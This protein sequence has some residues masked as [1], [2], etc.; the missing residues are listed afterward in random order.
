[1]PNFSRAKSGGGGRYYNPFYNQVDSGVI[2]EL[3]K[4]AK[5]V[6]ATVRSGVD[7]AVLEWSYRKTAY[8]HVKAGGKNGIAMGFDGPRAMTDKSGN[9]T[10]YDST[11]NV[12]A[13]PLLQSIDITNDGTVGSLLRGKFNFTYWPKQNRNSFNMQKVSNLFFVPGKEAQLS[14]GWS[15]GGSRNNQAFTGIIN[16]FNWSYN[17]DLSMNAEVSIVSAAS[18][19]IGISGD[20]T[21]A[22]TDPNSKSTDGAGVAIAGINIASMI[23]SDLARIT[24]SKVMSEAG[25]TDY[26]GTSNPLNK[27]KIL[28]YVCI[29]WP[30][31]DENSKGANVQTFWYTSVTRFVE[32][33]NKLIDDFEKG[34]A[35]GLGSIFQLQV[36]GN[37]TQHLPTIKSS[38]P[39]DVVFPSVQM[40]SYGGV[41]PGSWS[42]NSFGFNPARFY[43]PATQKF[44]VPITGKSDSELINIGGILISVNYIKDTY[45]NFIQENAAN[46]SY[47]NITKFVEDVLK[48][49]NVASGDMYQLSAV[50]CDNP[51]TMRGKSEYNNL[52]IAILSIEDTNISPV[53][54]DSVTAFK[55]EGNIF[56][57]LIKNINISSKPPAPL[58]AA[59]FTK[60]RG[61]KNAN[62]D[63]PVSANKKPD[64]PKKTQDEMDAHLA[65]FASG[66]FN[67]KWSET[68]RGLQSRLK[69]VSV[70][71]KN[72]HWLT[73]AIYPV[74]LSI[75][76]DGVSGFSFG[77]IVTTNLLP[78]EYV[79]AKMVFAV[80]KIDHKI[81]PHIW[82]TTLHTVCRLDA[83]S[84][85]GTASS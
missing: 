59:A 25:Q 81:T 74:E 60:A 26:I 41:Q 83:N 51:D 29:G 82:E 78:S 16:N 85:V 5:Y 10:L 62:N 15:V 4:R 2:S 75:T 63:T 56:K 13:Y 30:Y 84:P 71:G 61:S 17:T 38:Y 67:E 37:T 33:T 44:D 47:R 64:E 18:I 58:A 46:I 19:S 20:Q 27:N 68:Y 24:G 48:R 53:H 54:S 49:I 31:A 79:A 9:L 11:R 8:G 28:D 55:F 14:W 39:Q 3:N 40:G 77:N 72:G 7:D 73:K 1:M 57:P 36:D 42:A 76:I 6:G 34:G 70:P 80:T 69:K 12:P 35:A 32:A 52:E 21:K 66:G 23:D 65:T 45:R 22:E 43:N 50:L